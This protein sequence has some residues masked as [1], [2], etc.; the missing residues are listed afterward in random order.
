M[1]IHNIE[2]K[3]GYGGQIA[4]SAGSSA[5]I[6]KKVNNFCVIRTASGK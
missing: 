2:I 3:P 4:R 6:I 1:F 5:K